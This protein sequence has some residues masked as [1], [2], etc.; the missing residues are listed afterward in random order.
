MSAETTAR[1]HGNEGFTLVEVLM[2]IAL[3]SIAFVG[4]LTAVASMIAAGAENQHAGTA[5]TVVRNAGEFLKG[6]P[7]VACPSGPQSAY[8]GD[9]AAA[10][11]GTFP[12]GYAIDVS[13]RVWDQNGDQAHPAAFTTECAP[14]I[15]DTG[16]EL[17]TVTATAPAHPGT[18]FTKT[19]AFI[20]RQ[21]T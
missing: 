5:E 21:T 6:Q 10:P 7:Y 4:I 14:G 20:K 3:I 12:A 1:D 17:V 8:L 2:A 11:A 15:G 18:Q 19:L 9:I 16:L 13:V